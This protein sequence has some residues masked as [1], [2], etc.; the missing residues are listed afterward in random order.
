MKKSKALYL[1]I[2]IGCA[3]LL[4]LQA[5][6]RPRC[7]QNAVVDKK[8]ADVHGVFTERQVL[9]IYRPSKPSRAQ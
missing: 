2:L 4:L 5:E 3:D 6:Q 7:R 1:A 9:I 8:G